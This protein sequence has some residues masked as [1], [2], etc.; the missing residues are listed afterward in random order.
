MHRQMLRSTPSKRGADE[1]KRNPAEIR[2]P[3]VVITGLDGDLRKSRVDGRVKPGHDEWGE[4]V[5]FIERCCRAIGPE[6]ML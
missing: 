2:S 6:R 5:R 3:I 4:S 1:F